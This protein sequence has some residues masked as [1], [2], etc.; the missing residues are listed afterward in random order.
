[1]GDETVNTRVF[2]YLLFDLAHVDLEVVRFYSQFIGEK[3]TCILTSR[4]D[5]S[6]ESFFWRRLFHQHHIEHP[7]EVIFPRVEKTPASIMMALDA[8]KHRFPGTI[9]CLD[10][11]SGPTSQLY[12]KDIEN[13]SAVKIFTVDPLA[14]VY[15]DLHKKY[16]TG[17][18]LV[19]IPGYGEKLKELFPDDE[20][21]FVYSSNAI[22]HSQD[23]KTF[24]E[25]LYSILKPGGYLYL[26]GFVNEGSAANWL[27]LHR[28]NIEPDG[29]DLLL[30]NRDGSINKLN[31]T[32]HLN[33]N[34]FHKSVYN[35]NIGEED[36]YTVI[37]EKY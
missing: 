31:L 2:G 29:N 4:P 37:Y 9:L 7:Q 32:S 20:F 11:G 21:H 18:D 6:S 33:L 27:G 28:W 8:C 24:I 34:V 13:D 19:S 1:M 22:D 15:D 17:Y 36:I 14:T 30:S 25:N 26:H 10:C 5:L 23:P 12:T 35:S 16:N 3:L